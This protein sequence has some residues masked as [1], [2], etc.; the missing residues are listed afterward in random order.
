MIDLAK[1]RR[2]LARLPAT[3]DRPIARRNARKLVL[4]ALRIIRAK[5]DREFPAIVVTRAT[6]RSSDP[7]ARERRL[8]HAGWRRADELAGEYAAA[9]VP[10]RAVPVQNGNALWIPGWAAAIGP[11][12]TKLRAAKRS[13]TLQR[14]ALA[15]ALLK[16]S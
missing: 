13:V 16:G 5:L 3:A 7:R 4:S 12:P 8:L 9:G 15:A 11:N 14:A 2:S 10:V 1:L 6:R